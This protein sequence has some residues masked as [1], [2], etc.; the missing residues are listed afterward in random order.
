MPLP[1]TWK[2]ENSEPGN[3]GKG[4]QHWGG[5]DRAGARYEETGSWAPSARDG[6]TFPAV[7]SMFCGD[8]GSQHISLVP[9]LL[10]FKFSSY[11]PPILSIKVSLWEVKWI[12]QVHKGNH[13]QS[14]NSQPQRPEAWAVVPQIKQPA[15]RVKGCSGLRQFWGTRGRGGDKKEWTVWLP[16]ERDQWMVR[17]PD[18]PS[19]LPLL[20]AMIFTLQFHPCPVHPTPRP[21]Q[22]HLFY[23]LKALSPSSWIPKGTPTCWLES[24]VAT[25]DS[26]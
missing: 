25:K 9:V 22:I 18:P 11:K 5:T 6:L 20:S 7:S 8:W 21:L 3:R 12:A 16:P 2:L 1:G 19:N 17:L 13:R 4:P 14:R 10:C 26:S 23:P 24:L 15:Q